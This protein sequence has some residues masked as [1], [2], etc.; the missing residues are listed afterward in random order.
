[1]SLA[2]KL[3]DL[4]LWSKKHLLSFTYMLETL[5]TKGNPIDWFIFCIIFIRSFSSPGSFGLCCSGI[6]LSSF[7]I[8]SKSSAFCFHLWEQDFWKFPFMTFALLPLQNWNS[9]NTWKI[10][11]QHTKC[12]SGQVWKLLYIDELGENDQRWDYC[13]K[14]QIS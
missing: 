14:G 5:V 2:R 4:C 12:T 1:M 7:R 13:G 3:H 11:P 9:Y 8:A 10:K 6:R